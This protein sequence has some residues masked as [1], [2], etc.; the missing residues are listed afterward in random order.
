VTSE[1]KNKFTFSFASPS[2]FSYKESTLMPF[3]KQFRRKYGAD[4]TKMACLGFDATLN[5]C[6]E[7]LIG[8]KMPKGLI[9]NY[10]FI[11][12]GFGNGFQNNSSFVLEFKDFESKKEK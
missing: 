5:I 12:S 8:K 9:S 4:L 6:S 1:L 3:H 2:Y 7:F 11:Q 10:E